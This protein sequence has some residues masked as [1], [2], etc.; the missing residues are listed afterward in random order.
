MNHHYPQ[1]AC[2][3][4]KPGDMTTVGLVTVVVIAADLQFTY[5]FICLCVVC[6]NQ[7]PICPVPI[8]RGIFESLAHKVPSLCHVIAEIK[9]S[10]LLCWV[11]VAFPL[12]LLPVWIPRA[13]FIASPI[14]SVTLWN[15]WDFF[16]GNINCDVVAEALV[17]MPVIWRRKAR[18]G[19]ITQLFECTRKECTIDV[20][21][22]WYVWMATDFLL[23][24]T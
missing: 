12:W 22:Y 3:L 8:E 19:A 21:S 24:I 2:R 7:C 20:R 11:V 17:M 10:L 14:R 23:R 4:T 18:F 5:P 13:S 16:G 15:K 6:R 9:S 1:H